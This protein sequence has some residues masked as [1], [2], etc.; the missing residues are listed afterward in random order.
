MVFP[1]CHE[2][3]SAHVGSQACRTEPLSHGGL[4][5]TNG[6]LPFSLNQAELSQSLASLLGAGDAINPAGSP[7]AFG[8]QR[9]LGDWRLCV[10]THGRCGGS[11]QAALSTGWPVRVLRRG[12]PRGRSRHNS[13]RRHLSSYSH[14]CLVGPGASMHPSKRR[15]LS[16]RHS[17]GDRSSPG[18]PKTRGYSLAWVLMSCVT[19]GRALI[20]ESGK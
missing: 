8:I 4:L 2:L 1:T 13:G 15:A 17:E 10:L 19:S 14:D 11:S 16:W 20:S 5:S 6:C 12:C 3:F 18:I 9:L 7:T